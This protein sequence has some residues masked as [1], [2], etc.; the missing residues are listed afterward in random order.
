M[1]YLLQFEL[2]LFKW[3]NFS[4]CFSVL[5]TV[6]SKPTMNEVYLII[7]SYFILVTFLTIQVSRKF[8]SWSYCIFNRKL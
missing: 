3:F 4:L 8:S 2:K 5:L 7:I 6:V 1:R